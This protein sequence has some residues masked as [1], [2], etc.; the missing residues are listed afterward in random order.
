MATVAMNAGDTNTALLAWT[1]YLKLDP[2][3]PDAQA[4]KDWIAANSGAPT[5]APSPSSSSG[6]GP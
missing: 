1:K 2:N 6:G 4:I 5:P 3:A